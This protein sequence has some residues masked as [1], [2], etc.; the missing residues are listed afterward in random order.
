MKAWTGLL[1][2]RDR[3][4]R[5]RE[6]NDGLVITTGVRRRQNQLEVRAEISDGSRE[7]GNAGENADRSRQEH[8]EP[9]EELADR[10]GL[11]R[12]F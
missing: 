12:G 3:A 7:V 9:T 4:A 5:L 10:P 1:D 6:G 11:R 2:D 8:P